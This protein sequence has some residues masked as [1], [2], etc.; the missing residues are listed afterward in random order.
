[1]LLIAISLVSWHWAVSGFVGQFGFRGRFFTKQR[2]CPCNDNCKWFN[3]PSLTWHWSCHDVFQSTH[4]GML[5]ATV[6]W[7]GFLFMALEESQRVTPYHQLDR[8]NHKSLVENWSAQ[9]TAHIL[10][11]QLVWESTVR[12]NFA[13][14]CW[15]SKHIWTYKKLYKR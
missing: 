9:E 4:A 7:G 6:Q 11:T 12:L 1:M 13:L 3:R 2:C 5:R 10:I 15:S 14:C 8:L